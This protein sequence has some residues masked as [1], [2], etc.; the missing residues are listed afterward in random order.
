M[1]LIYMEEQ[2]RPVRRPS[3]WPLL[4]PRRPLASRRRGGQGDNLRRHA[5][6]GEA[7]TARE[8]TR[9][10]DANAG[11]GSGPR[12]PPP[13][14]SRTLSRTARIAVYS[15]EPMRIS[16]RANKPPYRARITLGINMPSS[17][18]IARITGDQLATNIGMQSQEKRIDDARGDRY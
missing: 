9:R 17:L 7:L 10:T 2:Q 3:R 5:A 14:Y 12:F 8:P 11:G 15:R 6:A 4:Q 1:G 13:L 18:Q 16:R